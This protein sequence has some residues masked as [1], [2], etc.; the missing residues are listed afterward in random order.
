MSLGEYSTRSRRDPTPDTIGA[1][2]A[3]AAHLDAGGRGRLH[4]PP[5]LQSW[6]GIVHGGGLV[7]LLDAAASALGGGPGPRVV[8]GR[9]TSSIPIDTA[10]GLEGEASGGEVRLTVRHE[11]Q[12]LTTASVGAPE[13][14]DGRSA[15][16]WPGGEEGWPM[17]MSEHCL[18]CG[19]LNPLGLRASL[20]FD[21]DGV[22]TRIAPRPEWRARSGRL[23][24]AFAP[25]LLDEIAWWL[26]ALLMK[27]GG[28]TN[29]IRVAF[30]APEPPWG[31]PL[32]ASGRFDAMSPVDRKRTFWRTESALATADGAPV[33]TASIVFRGGAEYSTR[34]MGYFRSRTP[35]D[36]F[37][38]MFPNHAV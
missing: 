4:A 24:P 1:A 27:E 9:L 22:W 5:P 7:A 14:G 6:P 11:G 30:A 32:V 31:V 28:L 13:P 3:A 25:V 21:E 15:R 26:G 37:R 19:A 18:A 33:A 35:P 36:V 34:Q 29:R 20:R 10:V 8:E 2:V 38:R 12:V 23:H 16:A 17:P